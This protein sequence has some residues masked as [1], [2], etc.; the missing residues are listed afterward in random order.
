MY[1]APPVVASREPV[2][3]QVINATEQC[4]GIVQR[5]LAGEFGQSDASSA[6]TLRCC[7]ALLQLAAVSGSV[8]PFVRASTALIAS[9]EAAFVKLTGPAADELLYL[10]YRVR[11][12][13]EEWR[14]ELEEAEVA[15]ITGV[16]P[17]DEGN[18]AVFDQSCSDGVAVQAD[19]RTVVSSTSDCFAVVNY[20]MTEVCLVR[21]E[22]MPG[23]SLNPCVAPIV[24]RASL[25]GPSISS[26]TS[27]VMSSLALA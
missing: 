6:A 1:T 3:S 14:S 11:V 21:S 5:L 15:D 27:L 25:R 20:P 9:R 10:L 8:V 4:Y 17:R 23:V 2:A 7:T 12:E 13:V 18:P 22:L 16:H 24:C 19:G 26:T